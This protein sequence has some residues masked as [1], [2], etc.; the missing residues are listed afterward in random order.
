MSINFD[1]VP[2]YIKTELNP[3]NKVVKQGS[4]GIRVKQ[5]QEWLEFHRFQTAIDGIYGPATSACVKSFQRSSGLNETGRVDRNTWNALVSPLKTALAP[6]DIGNNETLA[7]TIMTVADQ[8]VNQHPLEIG[9]SNSGP[10]VRVYCGGNEG[11]DWAW[12][13]GFVTLIMQ[14]ACFFREERAPIPGSVSCDSLAFQAKEKGMFVSK[15][16]LLKGDFRWA[17]F[18]GACFFLRRRTKT[19][20][21]HTGVA[22][23]AEGK[24]KNMVFSTVEGNTNDEGSREGYEA[25]RRTRSLVKH[26]DFI[27]FN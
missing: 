25:C 8:H 9:T 4:R 2:G 22:T 21:T 11:P 10:W 5:I 17:D 14:Q 7:T 16:A 13:A 15:T 1:N 26:Y 27:S 23:K 6:P 18:G 3:P 24:G 12:C 20:W 19:D